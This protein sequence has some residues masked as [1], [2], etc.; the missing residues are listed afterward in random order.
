M[1]ETKFLENIIRSEMPTP[2]EVFGK[3]EEEDERE[4]DECLD[5]EEEEEIEEDE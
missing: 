4:E 3:E 5:E 1:K 2:D